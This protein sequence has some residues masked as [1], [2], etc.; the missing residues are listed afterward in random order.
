MAAAAK[1]RNS[2]ITSAIR[3]FRQRGYAATGLNDILKDSGAP[4]G[5][6]Y[7]YFP[8]GK[9]QLG[10]EAVTVA[11]AVV[12][13]TLDEL[14][15]EKTSA[16][17]MLRGYGR[18]LA[19]WMA[20]AEYREGCP[21]ATTLLETTPQSQS[22]AKAGQLAFANWRQPFIEQLQ[23]DGV[24]AERAQRLA[25]LILITVEGAMLMARVEASSQPIVQA[26]DDLA[27]LLENS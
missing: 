17:D 6:L 11:G 21:I 1:H 8:G 12:A 22:L 20:Q 24:P 9:E 2:I 4:K 27:D 10:E 5:S 23:A 16:A 25:Q 19:G 18:L 3:L 15:A 14:R 26:C 7:H 13:K